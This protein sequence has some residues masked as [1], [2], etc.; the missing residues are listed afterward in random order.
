MIEER[1]I[2]C[3]T[4]LE[5][6]EINE[7]NT[8]PQQQQQIQSPIKQI[9]VRQRSLTTQQN[10]KQLVIIQTRTPKKQSM[11][12]IADLKQQILDIALK[13]DEIINKEQTQKKQVPIKSQE[14]QDYENII[15]DQ[16]I[17][18]KSLQN[19]IEIN[20]RRLQISLEDKE[21]TKLEDKLKYLQELEKILKEE[22]NSI[23]KIH[24][25]QQLALNQ[26]GINEQDE[27]LKLEKLNILKQEKQ[28]TKQLQEQLRQLENQS[29]QN[30]NNCYKQ[31][32]KLRWIDNRV[33]EYNKKKKKKLISKDDVEILE[34]QLH[35]LVQEIEQKNQINQSK[36]KELEK[37]RKQLTMDV[38]IRERQLKEKDKELKLTI[39]KFNEN[40]RFVIKNEITK[41]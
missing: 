21:I 13:F 32:E 34:S 27:K 5:Y 4:T 20:Q 38:E 2:A 19:Q 9:Q 41:Q 28:K 1:D 15:K 8:D 25:Q 24:N 35:E 23:K 30:H 29:K 11:A 6:N 40:K 16:M 33:Q 31:V 17:E 7:N 18:I 3:Q 39:M 10:T 14:I 37:E 12:H 26:L 22:N 36:L